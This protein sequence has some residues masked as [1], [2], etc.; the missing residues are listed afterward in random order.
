MGCVEK[1]GLVKI[2]DTYRKVAEIAK[3]GEEELLK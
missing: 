3:K 2:G 1:F